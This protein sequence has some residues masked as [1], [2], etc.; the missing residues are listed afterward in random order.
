MNTRKTTTSPR[1][2]A[3]KLEVRIKIRQQLDDMLHD[4][5]MQSFDCG[6]P[7]AISITR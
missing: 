5:L 7:V 1:T 4:A 3:R 2:P 6:D